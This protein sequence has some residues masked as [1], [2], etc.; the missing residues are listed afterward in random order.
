MFYYRLNPLGD[1][2]REDKK[3]LEANVQ[4]FPCGHRDVFE[5]FYDSIVIDDENSE[6][7][8]ALTFT[9]TPGYVAL[10]SDAMDI[11]L[12]ELRQLDNVQFGSII[13]GKT[14]CILPDWTTLR[15]P[16]IHVRGD[17]SLVYWI[18]ATC[19]YKVYDHLSSFIYLS[20]AD[21]AD[22]PLCMVDSLLALH[23]DVY[24]RLVVHS[25]WKRLTKK[26]RVEKIRVLKN[27]L[28]GYAALLSDS[29]PE[30]RSPK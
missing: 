10:R 25:A 13:N 7:K 12:P 4:R 18:C 22:R 21:V 29:P 2:I 26:V 3:W 20:N 19:G 5:T 30:I 6:F 1:G 15:M 16:N 24:E 11:L 17:K 27:N 14:G 9:W 23:E 28:D 8:Y